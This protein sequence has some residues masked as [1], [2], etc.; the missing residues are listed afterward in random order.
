M[1]AAVFDSWH[2]VNTSKQCSRDSDC[3]QVLVRK[4]IPDVDVKPCCAAF[5]RLQLDTMTSKWEYY[6][7][8]LTTLR[9]DVGPYSA[10][11]CAHATSIVA[12]VMAALATGLSLV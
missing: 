3:Q 2:E 11:Y 5:P 8:D 10:A 7:Y 1:Q 4:D 9:N 6:C 12:G